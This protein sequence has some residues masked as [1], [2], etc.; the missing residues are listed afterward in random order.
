M[1]KRWLGKKTCDFC[2]TRVKDKGTV[3]YDAKTSMGPWAFMCSPCFN[4]HGQR[5]GQMYDA[6]TLLKITDL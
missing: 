1:T 2:S 3:C 4:N 6:E 5:L